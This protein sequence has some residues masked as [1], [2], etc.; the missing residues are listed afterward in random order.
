M[1]GEAARKP[2]RLGRGLDAL[3]GDLPLTEEPP[4]AEGD[5]P[6]PHRIVP[7]GH[8]SPNPYQPR[9][10]FDPAELESLTDSIR[11]KGVLQPILVRP[12]PVAPDQFQ[13]IAG[14]RR[15]RAA[16]Q[17][18]LHEVPVVIRDLSDAEALHVAIIENIQRQDLSALEEA[19]GYRRLIQEFGHTQ[20]D[21][22]RA[23]GKSRSH[24]ANTLR[25]LDLPEGV[26]A[27]LQDGS[28]TAGHARALLAAEN[29]VALAGRVV[30]QGL[31]V[32]QTEE[33]ARGATPVQ[34]RP[35]AKRGS[36]A[37]GQPDSGM[38]AKDVDTLAL[39]EDVSARLG[40]Q[41]TVSPRSDG[42]GSLTIQYGTLDQLDDVLER[43]SHGNRG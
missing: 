27:L 43:L 41:V 36:S 39:E 19:Q 30:A 42:S 34:S 40:L 21:L 15:W 26:Q 10:H 29:P 32:R 25:L 28:L 31:T 38:A 9:R 1:S 33:V 6:R 13:I 5:S 3:F 8:L 18:Q 4:Q 14:E 24:I 2:Q 16:Q 35:R 11:T 37:A 7:V 22:A 23:V 12:D 20:E 17:A